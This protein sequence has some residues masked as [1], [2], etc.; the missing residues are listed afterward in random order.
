MALARLLASMKDDDGRVTIAHFY[1]G[2]EP[3]TDTEKRAIAEAPDVDADLR[4][5]L[6][7]GRT[8]GGGKKLVELINSRR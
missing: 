4:R 5:E 3:L 2:I 7:L 1:D 8:E 6:W